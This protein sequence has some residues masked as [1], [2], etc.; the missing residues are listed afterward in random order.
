M[1]MRVLLL[2]LEGKANFEGTGTITLPTA[3]VIEQAPTDLK[4]RFNAIESFDL[5]GLKNLEGRW[6][7]VSLENCS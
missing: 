1:G 2:L 5:S 4:E 3:V 7:C 6:A